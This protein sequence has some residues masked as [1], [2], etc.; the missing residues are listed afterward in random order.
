MEAVRFEDFVGI[1]NAL[2]KEIERIKTAEAARLGLKGA[3]VMCLYYLVKSPDG[4]TGSELARAC[5]VSRAAVSR[6]LSHLASEGIVGSTTVPKVRATGRSCASPSTA[7]RSPSR[8]S[9][10]SARSSARR[11][12]RSR[13][14]TESG[15]TTSSTRRWAA[16][17]AFLAPEP[18]NAFGRGSP[19]NDRCPAHP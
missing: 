9:T 19:R 10:S 2:H 16:F 6:T 5:D 7:A 4:M 15:C 18:P 1:V 11:G 8:C 17:A 12:T 13:S 14:A 3:D